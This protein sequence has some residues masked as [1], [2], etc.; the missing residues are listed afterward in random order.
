[1]R[2]QPPVTVDGR[3]VT[4]TEVETRLLRIHLPE[5]NVFGVAGA[6]RRGRSVAHGWVVLVKRL[7]RGT[8]TIEIVLDAEGNT[9]VTTIHVG[10]DRANPAIALDKTGAA[11]ATEGSLFTYSF[12]ATNIGNVTLTNVVLTDDKC[13]S[14]LKRGEPDLAD[15]SFDPG[16]EWFYSCTVT[17]PPGPAQVDNLAEV[18]GE[19]TRQGGQT[20]KVCAVD[21]HTF[22]VPPPS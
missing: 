18:C 1:M 16:D 6:D 7:A 8:H 3:R 21:P 4:A 20:T 17:A 12:K 10:N 13:Q 19:H 9:I 11:T 14:T 15:T 5:D 22:T 2:R